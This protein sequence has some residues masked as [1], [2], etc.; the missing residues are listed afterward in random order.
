MFLE[1]TYAIKVAPEEMVPGNL[2]SVN[3]VAQFLK[4][5]L[6]EAAA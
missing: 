6:G 4:R 1:S 2:D 3:R 5:K